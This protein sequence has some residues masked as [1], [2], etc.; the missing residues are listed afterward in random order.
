M[1]LSQNPRRAFRQKGATERQKVYDVLSLDEKIK[2]QLVFNPEVKISEDGTV[3]GT[4]KKQLRKLLEKKALSLKPK[5]E[6]KSK[7]PKK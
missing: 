1:E 7:E 2:A 4:P 3:T 6:E 5:N